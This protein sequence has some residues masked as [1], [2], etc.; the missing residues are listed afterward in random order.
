MDFLES[1]KAEREG[2]MRKED[3]VIMQAEDAGYLA[4]LDTV[5]F[6]LAGLM[7]REKAA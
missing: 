2:F 7:Q 5:R 1:E 3:N 4:A 6:H